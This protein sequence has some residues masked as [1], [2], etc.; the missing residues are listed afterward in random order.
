MNLE[1]YTHRVYPENYFYSCRQRLISTTGPTLPGS[2][3]RG[4]LL[5]PPLFSSL[6]VPPAFLFAPLVQCLDFIFQFQ[7]SIDNNE[8]HLGTNSWSPLELCAIS[9]S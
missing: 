2:E 5:S 7:L 3:K 1:S 4:I 6:S 9:L 8:P